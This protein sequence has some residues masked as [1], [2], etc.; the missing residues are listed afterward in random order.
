MHI[1][2]HFNTGAA[3]AG[4]LCRMGAS[5]ASKLL[6]HGYMSSVLHFS[7][8]FSIEGSALVPLPAARHLVDVR[9]CHGS[10]IAGGCGSRA[11]SS[12]R[13]PETADAMRGGGHGQTLG[14]TGMKQHTLR[15][16][17]W[18]RVQRLM[19]VLHSVRVVS[20]P[21]RCRNLSRQQLDRRLQRGGS[22]RFVLGQLLLQD[23]EDDG[24]CRGGGGK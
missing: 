8:K 10:N 14:R 19:V 9:Y 5:S 7:V 16:G 20:Q 22:E 17:G 15:G 12:A 6:S 13:L 23:L 4:V 21:L 11:D 3:R 1:V 18:I 24:S 2:S